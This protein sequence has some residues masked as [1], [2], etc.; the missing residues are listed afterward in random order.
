MTFLLL[1][2]YC[3]CDRGG[4]ESRVLI[5]STISGAIWAERGIGSQD[6]FRPEHADSSS[7]ILQYQIDSVSV[8][9]GVRVALWG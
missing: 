7:K 2:L 3:Y 1:L 6:R 4:F 9:V 8:L 5:C